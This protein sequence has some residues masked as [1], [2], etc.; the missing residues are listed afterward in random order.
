MVVLDRFGKGP[1]FHVSGRSGHKIQIDVHLTPQ[2]S[3]DT[4]Y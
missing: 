3:A 2:I 4:Q 1:V